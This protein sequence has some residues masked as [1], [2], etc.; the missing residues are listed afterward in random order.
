[1]LSERRLYWETLA[2]SNATN[3]HVL[4]KAKRLAVTYSNLY[5]RTGYGDRLSLLLEFSS[6]IG[7]LLPLV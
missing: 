4:T 6:I 5:C 7:S 2:P 3:I 1:M